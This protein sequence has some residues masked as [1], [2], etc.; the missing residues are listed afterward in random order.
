MKII[1][2]ALLGIVG[3][4]VLIISMLNRHLVA[5]YWNPF[6]DR[7]VEQADATLMAPQTTAAFEL[8]MFLLLIIVLILGISIG[9][10]LE[11]RRES[12]H[13]VAA[14]N[15]EAEV[16]KLRAEMNRMYSESA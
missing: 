10:I 5:F 16:A 12:K 4:I 15:R 6:E 2:L 14:R 13:R 8:P 7:M 3:L 11:W 1:K 9:V